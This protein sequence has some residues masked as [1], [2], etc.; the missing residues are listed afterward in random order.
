MRLKKFFCLQISA[1]LIGGL[2]GTL[3]AWGQ[4]KKPAAAENA[5]TVNGAAIATAEYHGEVLAFQRAVLNAG[6]L[7]T[8]VQLAAIGKEV[9][10]SLIR[11][12]ILYQ[13]SRKAGVGTDRKDIDRDLEALKKKFLSEAE[14]QKELNRRNL[15]E[16]V[17][18]AQMERGL[19]IQTYVERQFL[20]KA[21]V[22]DRDV[23]AYYESHLPL[24]KQPLQV[25]AYHLLIQSDVQ[26]E[27]SRKQEARRK[28]E[29]M[30]KELKNGKDFKELARE[31]SDGPTRTSGGDLGY[32]KAGQLDKQFETV[33]FNMKP[34][35][36]SDIV[37]T[38]YGFH[39]F[40]VSDRR[41]ESILAYDSVKEQIRQFLLLEKAKREADL[42]A[43]RLRE[44]ADVQ[45]LLNEEAGP[46]KQ[47]S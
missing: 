34:G 8:C 31:H 41:P 16:D 27:A 5:A 45:I 24:L 18:A 3:P 42:H 43:R 44:Q 25:R 22:T 21:E 15:T 20:S 10:E 35:D 30:K 6:K 11:R 19:A 39:L 4:E 2:I 9:M 46:A 38:D 37:E 33:V 26:W 1:V 17:L 36:I 23:I 32:V 14:Y 12:E 47:P 40:Q 29:R 7:L 28:A 13:E